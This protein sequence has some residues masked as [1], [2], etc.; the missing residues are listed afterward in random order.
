MLTF[1][2]P[3]MYCGS[4]AISFFVHKVGRMG[5]SILNY[6]WINCLLNWINDKSFLNF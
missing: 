4:F 6:I 1:N 2:G 3:K 5:N